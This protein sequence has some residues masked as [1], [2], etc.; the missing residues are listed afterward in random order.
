MSAEQRIEQYLRD[1]RSD[2]WR[3]DDAAFVADV[4]SVLAE[5]QAAQGEL[6]VL[7]RELEAALERA[8]KAERAERDFAKWRTYWKRKAQAAQE[9]E[10]A[11]REAAEKVRT[12]LGLTAYEG[13]PVSV[14]SAK[15]YE[16]ILADALAAQ[17]TEEAV[18]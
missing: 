10:K 2:E 4:R 16:G 11:L 14:W 9:R 12:G 6:L 7:G 3:G 1:V 18:E 17:R 13:T 15:H 5:L 8:D